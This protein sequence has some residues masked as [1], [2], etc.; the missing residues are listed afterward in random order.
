M[1][2]SLLFFII[3]C[4]MNVFSQELKLNENK[5]YIA[6]G[7]IQFDSINKNVLFQKS[8]E[9]ININYKNEKDEILLDDKEQFNIIAKGKFLINKEIAGDKIN[10]TLTLKFL[11]NKIIYSYSGFSVFDDRDG[12]ILKIESLNEKGLKI[13]LP[14][15]QEQI[16][17]NIQNL[18]NSIVKNSNNEN[19]EILSQ[20]NPIIP[21]VR[22]VNWGM[23]KEQ[24]KEKE[25]LTNISIKNETINEINAKLII[26]SYSC[27]VFYDFYNNKLVSISMIFDIDHTNK[28]LFVNDYND[29]KKSLISKYGEPKYDK[30]DWSNELF[31]DDVNYIGLA[32]SREDVKYNCTWYTEKSKIYLL[33]SGNEDKNITIGLIYFD[34]K[35]IDR[36][37]KINEEKNK[38]DF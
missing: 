1:K 37:K 10:H 27:A 31:K 34:L 15:I 32:I 14:K 30:I 29:I 24:V 19:N 7:V 21:D 20:N 23:S 35:D 6:N 8:K 28:N 9:W 18:K 16:I 22:N 4:S 17:F 38:N 2:K 12:F 36:L 33:M 11:D 5:K 26:S 25:N 3:I 13:Y